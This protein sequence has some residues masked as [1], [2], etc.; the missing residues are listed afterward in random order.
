MEPAT[1]H[2]VKPIHQA[3]LPAKPRG[4]AVEQPVGQHHQ[5]DDRDPVEANQHA[6]G[7]KCAAIEHL[8][9]QERRHGEVDHKGHDHRETARQRPRDNHRVRR[10]AEEAEK[11]RQQQS[12]QQHLHGDKVQGERHDMKQFQQPYWRRQGN[13][14]Y[15]GK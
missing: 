6:A 3:D 15:S 10:A 7:V 12:A 11:N 1:S 9:K 5:A 4:E 14:V 2:A 13:R 8:G